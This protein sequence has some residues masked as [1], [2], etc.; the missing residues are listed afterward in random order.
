[1]KPCVKSYENE[2]LSAVPED[3]SS[4]SGRYRCESTS[5]DGV[6][7]SAVANIWIVTKPVF[8]S[9]LPATEVK[10]LSG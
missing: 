7:V 1:M 6:T 8:T 5:D 2:S 3:G 4:V 10:I 9:E